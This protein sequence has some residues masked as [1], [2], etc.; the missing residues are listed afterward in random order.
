[1]KAEAEAWAQAGLL[2]EVVDEVA[3]LRLNRPEKRNALDHY[4]GGSG[5]DGMGLRDALL[6]AIRNASED[7]GVKAAVITANG[8]VFSA[9]ADLRQPGGAL[10][11]PADR[12]RGPT[13][14]R[15]DGVLYGWYRLF[16]AIWRSETTFIAAVNGP[17]IGAGCQLALA[18]DLIYASHSATFWEIF[19]RI[20]LPIE[21]G[22]AFLLTRSLS[23]PRAKEMALLAEPLGAEKA[24]EWGLINQAVPADELQAVAAA[25]A[26]KLAALGPPPTGPAASAPRRDLSARLGHIKGQINAAWEQTM[27]QTFREEVSLLNLPAGDTSEQ[28]SESGG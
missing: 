6:F 22:A 15:D 9:G 3:W 12:R 18:C 19:G 5:P 23:L 17:A 7:K 11:I 14:A 24:Q 26:H 21:G 1:M 16:E 27:W 28:R 10:E 8:S 20:G 13:V 4:P 25:T 2:Y